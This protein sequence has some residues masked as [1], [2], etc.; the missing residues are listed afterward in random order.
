MSNAN[1]RLMNAELENDGIVSNNL[2]LNPEWYS[3]GRIWARG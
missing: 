2:N 3:A 1:D